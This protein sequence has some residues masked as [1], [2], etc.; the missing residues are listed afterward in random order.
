MK[1][2]V[3]FVL[4]IRNLADKIA[5][6]MPKAANR[7]GKILLSTGNIIETK[8]R[9]VDASTQQKEFRSEYPQLFID[10]NNDFVMKIIPLLKQ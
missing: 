8:R 7:K 3:R 4:D 2:D 5:S 10:V 6:Y 9:I 1:D